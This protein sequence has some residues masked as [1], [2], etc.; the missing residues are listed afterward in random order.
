MNLKV[1]IFIFLRVQ[2][3]QTLVNDD[4]KF[5][6]SFLDEYKLSIGIIFHCEKL[7]KKWL[8]LSEI[9]L[10]YFSFKKINAHNLN[11]LM[12]LKFNKIGI[13]ID[14]S[15]NNIENFF[16]K[17]SEMYFFN[18]SYNWLLLSDNYETSVKLLTQQNINL[19]AEITLAI[20]TDNNER[21]LYDVYKTSHKYHGDL[22]VT[23]WGNYN[24]RFHQ[25][26]KRSKFQRRNDLKGIK[27]NVGIVATA[28]KKNETLIEY[29][30][31]NEEFLVDV[32]HRHHYQLF[33]VLAEKYNFSYF[34]HRAPL[35]GFYRNGTYNG[36]LGMYESNQID[37][38]VTPFRITIDRFDIVDFSIT[39]WITTATI[40]FRHP[41]NS[42][43][44]AFLQPLSPWV[45]NLILIILFVVTILIMLTMRC[46]K[47]DMP[48]KNVTFIRAF[49]T[50]LGIMCQQGF[51][52]NFHCSSTR[53][54]LLISIFFSQIV[55]QF[56]SSFIVGSLLTM[57]PKTINDLRQLIDSNL[58]VGI[59]DITYNTDFFQTT[60]DPLALELYDKKILH[61]KSHGKFYPIE[62]GIKL[63]Q[64]GAFAYHFDTS[65]GNR[66]IVQNFSATEI[67]ELHEMFLFPPRPLSVTVAK[68]SPFKE[69]IMVEM[70]RFTENGILNYHN[71]KWQ[72][73]KPK[74]ERSITEFK[75]MDLNDASWILIILFT[76]INFSFIVLI[77]EKVHFCIYYKKELI[78]Q[79]KLF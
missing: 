19:D 41:K 62:D 75:A 47:F 56:Y 48:I 54:V 37:F 25:I 3:S 39:T 71:T 51:M 57:P 60:T 78:N 15:C 42:L 23:L 45:W 73:K 44:N 35:W 13:F 8:D 9:D 10:K 40:T 77:F 79:V 26:L 2:K 53:F 67:C 63:M 16:N 58:Q 52:E 21:I 12:N 24:G 31:S 61:G 4:Q 36:I 59:E 76:A 68:R 49:M 34:F 43:R 38:S 29:L 69:L 5:F 27:I 30:E 72:T 17:I 70:I 22:I 1:F 55:Y 64:K 6:I 14:L 32:Q 7:N 33:K 20:A 66:I 11:S 28:V 50:S 46:L 18:A 65:Y 74:C